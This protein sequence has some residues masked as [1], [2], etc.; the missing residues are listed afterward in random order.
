LTGAILEAHDPEKLLRHRLNLDYRR[1]EV[2]RY[3]T[4]V[5]G[6]TRTTQE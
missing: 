1:R 5:S 6:R 2:A 4:V 3:P